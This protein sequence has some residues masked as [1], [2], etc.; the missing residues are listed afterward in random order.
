MIIRGTRVLANGRLGPSAIHVLYG[1]ISAVTEFGE[2]R[3]DDDIIEAGDDVVM[4]GLVDTHVHVNEP[5]RTEWEGFTSATHAAAAGGITTIYDMPLNSIPATTSVRALAAKRDAAAGNCIIDVGFIGGVVPGNANELE[6]LHAQGIRL[7]K[8]FLVPSGV[9]EF[10]AVTETDLRIAMPVLRRLD[11][12]LMVHAELPG[13]INAALH[14][15]PRRYRTYLASR[16]ASA[17]TEAIALIIRLAAELGTRVHIVHVSSAASL[18]QIRE[19]RQRGIR[20]TCETCP[21]Y[22]TFAAEEIP[23]GATQFKCAPPIRSRAD[24]ELLWDAVLT[25]D[26]DMI[27]SDHSPCPP[28]MKLRETGDFL[29]AWGGIASLQ[30]SLPSVWHEGRKRGLTVDRLARLMCEAPAQLAGVS[31]RKGRLAQGFDADLFIWQP[32]APVAVNAATLYH[33]H[34]VSPYDGLTLTGSV[35]ATFARGN[36]VFHDGRITASIR[37]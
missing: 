4:P 3:G 23:D 6:G 26:I 10:P 30:V 11:A 25:G 12:T 17:E 15:D 13:H 29:H 33:R 35:T 5:G 31:E 34:A 14:G 1:V 32:D 20:I 19:A 16:P 21:H 18:P 27:A 36:A 2:T 22:L 9:E 24:R 8:C 28:G 7:F 37:A